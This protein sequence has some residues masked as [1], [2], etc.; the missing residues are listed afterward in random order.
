[1][2]AIVVNYNGGR[3]L[4]ECIKLLS[5][6]ASIAEIVV[7]D[8]ASMDT[9]IQDIGPFLS[10]R[11]KVLCLP[12]NV[13]YGAAANIGAR[14]ATRE[15][16]VLLN[17]DIKPEPGCFELL[18]ERLRRSGGI[19]GPALLNAGSEVADMGSTIDLM[20]L[21]KALRKPGAP[22]YVQGCCLATTRVCF[23]AIGG[24]DER[25]F[26]FHEDTEYCWQALRRGFNVEIVQHA[27][28]HHAGGASIAGGYKRNGYIEST[29]FRIVLRERNTWALI[30][31]CAPGRWIPVLLM[32]SL[33]RSIAFAGMV[34]KLGRP[35]SAWEIVSSG[36]WGVNQLRNTLQRR[37]GGPVSKSGVD[38]AWRRV[39]KGF[40]LFGALWRRDRLRLVD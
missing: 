11:T 15:Y 9:S 39:H 35:G 3:T 23:D 27:R 10:T 24:F 29:A 13:G 14:E 31:A 37:R 25:Y 22:L 7:V 36:W 33:V 26:L 2:S 16:L 30:M 12:T 21:P 18:L 6:E 19:V 17:P 4:A 20:C 40:F 8:N 34:A 28:V 1:M 38:E 5:A 32:L